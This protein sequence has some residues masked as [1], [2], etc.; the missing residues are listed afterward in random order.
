MASFCWWP[1]GGYLAV[2]G[3][4]APSGNSL[5]SAERMEQIL[6]LPMALGEVLFAFWL[7][8]RG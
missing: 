8:V 5:A 3:S 2:H 1:G 7:I 6:M 4:K